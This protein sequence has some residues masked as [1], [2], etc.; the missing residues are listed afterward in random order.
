MSAVVPI[1]S[2]NVERVARQLFSSS[3]EMRAFLCALSEGGAAQTAVAW[4]RDEPTAKPFVCAARPPWLPAWIDVAG[5]GE[6]PGKGESHQR[7]DIY[8][9]DLSST[10]ACATCSEIAID[11]PLVIDVCAAPGGK[12]ILAY[13][14]LKPSFTIANEVIRKR[15]APLVSNYKRCLIDPAVVISY[16]PKDLAQR[17]EAAAHLVIVDAPCSGQSLVLKDKAAPGAFHPATIS[18]N[19][20]RQRRILAH[21]QALVA[22]GGYLL[23]ST[24][25]FS[26]E[27]NEDVVE[28]FLKSFPA[29]EA[30]SVAAL[31]PF[32]STLT[33]AS[34]YRLW[35]QQGYGAGSFAALFRLPGESKSNPEVVG[36]LTANLWTVWRSASCVSPSHGPARTT[37]AVPGRRRKATQGKKDKHKNARWRVGSGTRFEGAE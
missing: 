27:E 32:Q 35:P 13:R 24:C 8:C 26:R 30:V 10:F 34:C 29:F 21:S 6:R 20:R 28:W 11:S 16:D 12:G 15:T 25:T 14:Y 3:E 23:Y 37:G 22:Q 5:T 7:G 36:E 2:R 31:A 9:L 4:L 18:M 17:C 1:P 19:E 33:S